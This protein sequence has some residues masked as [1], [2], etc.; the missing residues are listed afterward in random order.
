MLCHI[1]VPLAVISG[2]YLGGKSGFNAAIQ[3][4]W[5]KFEIGFGQLLAELVH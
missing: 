4:N 5:D 3:N 1:F 2:A